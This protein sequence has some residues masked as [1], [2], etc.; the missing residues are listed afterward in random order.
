[1]QATHAPWQAMLQQ[2]LSAQWPDRQLSSLWQYWPL[3]SFPQLPLEK[4]QV[5]C[6]S[7][8]SESVQEGRKQVPLAGLQV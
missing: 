7:H 5:C 6:E 4:S 1:M 8:W 2:T 3:A